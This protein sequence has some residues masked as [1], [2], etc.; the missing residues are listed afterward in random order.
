M[1]D[2]TETV[3]CLVIEFF[4]YCSSLLNHPDE[5]TGVLLIPSGCLVFEIEPSV[6]LCHT[7][8]TFVLLRVE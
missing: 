7:I 3:G 4:F 6:S 8:D 1:D 2:Q 5:L